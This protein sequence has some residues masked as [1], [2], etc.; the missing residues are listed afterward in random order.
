MRKLIIQEVV[1]TR[2]SQDPKSL[3]YLSDEC[4]IFFSKESPEYIS[5]LLQ[6]E[7]GVMIKGRAAENLEA[8]LQLPLLAYCLPAR[9][10]ND[11]RFVYSLY[12]EYQRQLNQ[13]GVFDT[14]DIVLST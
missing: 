6:H 2:L 7:I 3:D 8:Y 14:D 12:G 13:S 5:E 9:T 11:K 10:Q 4:K 1:N